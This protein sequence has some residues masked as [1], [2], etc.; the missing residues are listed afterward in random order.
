MKSNRNAK[1]LEEFAALTNEELLGNWLK[2]AKLIFLY[3]KITWDQAGDKARKLYANNGALNYIDEVRKALKEPPKGNLQKPKGKPVQ[4]LSS[5]KTI[6]EKNYERLMVLIP[7]LEEM[8]LN[9]KG[10][11]IYGRSVRVPYLDLVFELVFNDKT[12]FYISLAQ[13]KEQNGDLISYPEIEFLVNVHKKTVEALEFEKFDK[14][15]TSYD[16]KFDRNVIHKSER[17]ALNDFLYQ[18]LKILKNQEG[19]KIK[20]EEDPLGNPSVPHSIILDNYKKSEKKKDKNDDRTPEVKQEEPVLK[21]VTE[22]EETK[23]KEKEEP[24]E[25][26]KKEAKIISLPRQNKEEQTKILEKF[27]RIVAFKDREDGLTVADLQARLNHILDHIG[28]AEYLIKAW[29]ELQTEDHARLKQLNFYRIN[30]LIPEILKVLNDN[31]ESIR[32]VSDRS[33]EVFTI[34]PGDDRKKYEVMIGI[35]QLSGKEKEPTLLLKLNSATKRLTVGLSTGGFF[36]M[37]EFNHVPSSESSLEAYQISIFIEK[38]L[39]FM[40]ENSFRFVIMHLDSE[41]KESQEDELAEQINPQLESQLKYDSNYINKEIPDF[42]IGKVKLTETHIKYG[43]TQEIIDHI[44]KTGEGVT[45]FP[46]TKIMINNTK[47]KSTDKLIQA[48]RP[49]FRLSATGKFYY[50]GRS[51]RSDRTDQGL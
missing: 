38:W 2:F 47:S 51:N 19:H 29:D 37:P 20:W 25:E 12:G 7:D 31:T 27:I 39:N 18:W 13:Y 43:V 3:E 4:K 49:G 34:V 32:L 16:D 1:T 15:V 9:Y 28:S 11:E 30:Y 41:K 35:Y 22:D 6:Y 8:L 5:E 40:I 50:E 23:P 33:K 24:K 36:G 48:K 17:K 44:N 26:E 45:I 10:E 14:Y 46:R 21:K 42:E